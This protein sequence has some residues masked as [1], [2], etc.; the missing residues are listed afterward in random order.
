[1]WK[2]LATQRVDRPLI[3]FDLFGTLLD[4]T[5]I[6]RALEHEGVQDSKGVAQLWRRYQL[7]CAFCCRVYL[8]D[9]GR[10]DTRGA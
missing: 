4:T 10:E 7:E 3:A 5:S 8:L 2:D 6:A 9:D 1:M